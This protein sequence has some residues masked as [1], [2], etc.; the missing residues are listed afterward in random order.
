[1]V[2][3]ENVDRLATGRVILDRIDIVLCL[4]EFS[5]GLSGA[6]KETMKVAVSFRQSR[7]IGGGRLYST[8]RGVNDREILLIEGTVLN[9]HVRENF[10]KRDQH[11]AV[12][13]ITHLRNIVVGG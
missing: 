2:A 5:A 1:M 8:K 13:G 4:V 12:Y 9:F 7:K 6:G 10:L 11:H 3:N